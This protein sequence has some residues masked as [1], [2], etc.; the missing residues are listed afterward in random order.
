MN[1]FRLSNLPYNIASALIEGI[2][3]AR[4][5][6]KVITVVVVAVIRFE[7]HREL[8]CQVFPCAT[9]VSCNIGIAAGG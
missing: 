5:L 3:H 8:P 2:Y 6:G 7:P 1:L 9:K 4:N